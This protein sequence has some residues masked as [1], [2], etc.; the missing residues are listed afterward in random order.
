MVR[1]DISRGGPPPISTGLLYY[2]HDTYFIRRRAHA[3]EAMPGICAY[4]M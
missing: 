1:T 3:A 4:D 2:R